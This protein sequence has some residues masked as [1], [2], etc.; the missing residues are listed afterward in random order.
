[1][2]IVKQLVLAGALLFCSFGV[3]S[4]QC[5]VSGTVLSLAKQIA[6]RASYMKEVAAIKYKA[7]GAQISPYSAEQEIKVLRS[8]EKVADELKLPQDKLMMYAQ[9]QMD[10]SKQIEAYWI[11]AWRNH[12]SKIPATPET[13]EQVRA[14]IQAVNATLYPAFKR[15]I[16]AMRDCS[17]AQ[18]YQAIS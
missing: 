8:V 6:L 7:Y 11:E 4:Q 1:M 3:F 18:I 15:A 10:L 9:I 13:L 5:S 16:P 2:K 17:A 14:K 12:S